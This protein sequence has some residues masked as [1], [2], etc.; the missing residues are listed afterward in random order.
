[1]SSS[2]M[3]NPLLVPDLR[4]LLHAGETAVLR[5][6]LSDYHPARV[7]EVIEDLGP[8]EGD[9][10]FGLLE[11]RPRAGVMSYLDH[12]TQVRLVERMEPADAAALLHLMSHDE[13]A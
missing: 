1:M 9:T 7:A 5:D 8:G 12:E 6:F 11:P 4:E 10:V 2:R 3:R 13:R